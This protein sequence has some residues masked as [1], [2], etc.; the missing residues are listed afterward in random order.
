MLKV[1]YTTVV[2]CMENLCLLIH[3]KESSIILLT[4]L[5]KRSMTSSSFWLQHAECFAYAF[6]YFRCLRWPE[7]TAWSKLDRICGT[8]IWGLSNYNILTKK[9]ICFLL[10]NRHYYKNS[11][12]K[13][14]NTKLNKYLF[15]CMYSWYRDKNVPLQLQ[16]RKPLPFFEKPYV[17]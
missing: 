10:K 1:V 5:V 9:Y 15:F 11:K 13:K 16:Q 7:I 17:N 12:D 8:K 4:L 6:K 14:S 2:K 3:I